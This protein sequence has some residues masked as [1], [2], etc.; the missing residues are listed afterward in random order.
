MFTLLSA[1]TD[2]ITVDTD[3]VETKYEFDFDENFMKCVDEVVSIP[4]LFLKG[5][6][7]VFVWTDERL[8][9]AVAILQKSQPLEKL[10]YKLCPGKIT[11]EHFWFTYFALLDEALPEEL[12]L[13]TS[14]IQFNNFID[15]DDDESVSSNTVESTIMSSAPS[16]QGLDWMVDNPHWSCSTCL[17]HNNSL[18]SECEMCS[19]SQ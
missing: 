7:D 2:F 5:K 9:H 18:S 15:S 10:R 11:E 1:F 16:S 8:S 14:A 13:D 19:A 12:R 6:K 17:Y 4:N 3:E